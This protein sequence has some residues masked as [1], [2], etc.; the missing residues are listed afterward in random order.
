MFDLVY[1]SF[2]FFLANPLGELGTLGISLER[3][4]SYLAFKLNRP[5]SKFPKKI[6]FLLLKSVFN[7]FILAAAL[8]LYVYLRPK[9]LHLYLK[10][11]ILL[12][13]LLLYAYGAL[14]FVKDFEFHPVSFTLKNL[15]LSEQRATAFTPFLQDF[16][17]KTSNSPFK[18]YPVESEYKLDQVYISDTFIVKST[19][20]PF[21][22]SFLSI[23]PIK[24]ETTVC[25]V[26]T[27]YRTEVSG[28]NNQFML[29]EI[30]YK[31]F[32]FTI[33]VSTELFTEHLLPMIQTLDIN[34]RPSS[35]IEVTVFQKFVSIW[36]QE[37]S[38]N[39]GFRYTEESENCMACS[40]QANVFIKSCP[41]K[42]ALWCD[43]CLAQWWLLKKKQTRVLPEDWLL[44]KGNC[45]VCR[46]QYSVRDLAYISFT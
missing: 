5:N 29:L 15:Y 25:C 31:R 18:L 2:L 9:P 6:Q 27:D 37:I 20:S 8:S 40:N 3:L 43:S 46:R 42:K 30:S 38:R 45:P 4:S 13:S 28:E 24:S 7:I 11:T 34:Y 17:E 39:G 36:K 19:R 23:V 22:L 21:S 33:N 10:L 32:S 16:L 26:R 12:S 41:C 44:G 1:F 35:N 14:I